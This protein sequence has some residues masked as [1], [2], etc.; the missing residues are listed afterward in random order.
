MAAAKG[1]KY[2]IGNKGGRPGLFASADDL[3]T[4][5]DEYFNGGANK[6]KIPIGLTTV[7]IPYYTI[8]G[9]AYYLGF[10]SRQ[11]LLDYEKR[12]EYSDIIK[13]ARLR[14]EMAYE[15]CLMD[16]SP[17]GAIFALKNMG[18]SDRSEVDHNVN[19]SQL[20][21]IIIKTNG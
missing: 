15:E 3:Q 13:K 16:K 14:I 1:N 10:S 18:W 6:R 2:A 17:T 4:K 11:S 7:E 5:I 9:L 12:E 20:P 19:V 8:C 21:N